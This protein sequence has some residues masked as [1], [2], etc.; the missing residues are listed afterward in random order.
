MRAGVYGGMTRKNFAACVRDAHTAMARRTIRITDEDSDVE[1]TVVLITDDNAGHIVQSIN[2]TSRNGRG[3]RSEDLLTLEGVGLRLPPSLGTIA[4]ATADG[5]QDALP[6][7]PVEKPAPPPLPDLP[8]LMPTLPVQRPASPAPVEKPA[9][10]TPKPRKSKSST[11]AGRHQ[12]RKAPPDHDLTLDY[13]R[14]GRSPIRIAQ[15]YGVPIYVVAR[16]LTRL[17]DRGLIGASKA[18]A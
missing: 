6:P 9:P 14:L 10:P 12:W 2:L 5:D 8:D 15:E 17:R 13:N 11:P 7:A 4:G 1:T 18:G 16:W 3:I